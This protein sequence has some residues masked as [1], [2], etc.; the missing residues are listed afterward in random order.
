MLRN[1]KVVSL[2]QFKRGVVQRLHDSQVI[3]V[4]DARA[5]GPANASLPATEGNKEGKPLLK[6]EYPVYIMHF[7]VWHFCSTRGSKWRCKT[8]NCFQTGFQPSLQTK[9]AIIQKTG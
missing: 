6:N 1:K 5:A 4:T 3:N 7:I 9:S 8:N 2:L